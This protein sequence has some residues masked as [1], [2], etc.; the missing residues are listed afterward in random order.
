MLALVLGRREAVG[1]RPEPLR[2][3]N[4]TW[5]SGRQVSSGEQGLVQ[6]RR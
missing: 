2:T 1:P 6:P 3:K 4:P 5:A